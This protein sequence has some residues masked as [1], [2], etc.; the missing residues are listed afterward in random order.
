MDPFKILGIPSDSTQNEIRKRYLS[1]AKQYHPDKHQSSIE[2]IKKFQ[3]LES[4]YRKI[5]D[6]DSFNGRSSTPTSTPTTSTPRRKPRRPKP[7]DPVPEP[8][9]PPPPPPPPVPKF[10]K[11]QNFDDFLNELKEDGRK[12]TGKKKDKWS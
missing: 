5:I 12:K 9:P 2:S 1:L 6:A 10:K 4:A 11:G 3:D 8:P 7:P